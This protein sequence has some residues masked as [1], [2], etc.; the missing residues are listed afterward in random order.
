MA[1]PL[2]KRSVDDGSLRVDP[3]TGFVDVLIRDGDLMRPVLAADLLDEAPQPAG[4]DE[5]LDGASAPL[6]IQLARAH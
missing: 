2:A 3:E 5:P 6:R 1:P 4:V